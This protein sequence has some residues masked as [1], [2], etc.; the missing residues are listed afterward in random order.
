MNPNLNPFLKVEVAKFGGEDKGNFIE[1]AYVLEEI[2]QAVEKGRDKLLPR[3]LIH[4]PKIMNKATE[5][6][7]KKI[8][9]DEKLRQ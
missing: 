2:L 1:V 9:E 6:K 8:E 5:E 4:K 7:Q 3:Q